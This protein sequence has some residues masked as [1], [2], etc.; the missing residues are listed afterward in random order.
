L[1][2]AITLDKA[3]KFREALD[4]YQLVLRMRPSTKNAEFIE[5][6]IIHLNKELGRTKTRKN[7]TLVLVK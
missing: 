1:G 7:L 4:G 5:K 2:L 6:R 3:G